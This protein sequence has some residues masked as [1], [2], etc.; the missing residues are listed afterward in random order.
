MRIAVIGAGAMGRWAVK[1]LALSAEVDEIVVGDYNDVQA[2]AVAEAFGGA[3]AQPVFVDARD[4]ESVKK[5]IAGCDSLV[6]ATQ[7]FW[8]I[9]VMHAA[10]AAKV[11]YTDMGGLFHVT[12]QQV[13]LAE[14]FRKAGVTAVIAMGGAPGVT[15]ILAK[16][17]AERLDTVE[18]AHALCGNVDDTDWSGYDGWVVPYSL[19]TLCD[20]FSVTAP[21]FVD[22]QWVMDIRG[23]EGAEAIDFGEPAGILEAHYT[24][25]SEPFTFWHTWKDQGL[26]SATFKLS[27]PA[28]FT[29]Q[30]R[31]LDAIGMTRTDEVE[32]RGARVRP[33][34]V[35]LKVV[36][37]IPRPVDVVLDDVDYLIGV[38][39][40]LEGGRRVEWRVR[41]V[42]PAHKEYGAGGGDV[43]TG[44]PPAIVA[45]MMARGD[46]AGPGVFVPEQIVPCE[47]F[48]EEFAR[49]GVTVDA[50]RRELLAAPPG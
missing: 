28:E 31:F 32:I 1:E 19:E 34:D 6:N 18:E 26:R 20:E 13:E 11:H 12:K 47:A 43:D 8:N 7:H 29:G 49:W 21:E 4:A 38:V 50:Q 45:R 33:R 35:L 41:A 3:K 2:R 22:G 48:F 24:I 14:E 37:D 10:A 42:V 25:H 17:G 39:R 40:G 44:I 30:M 9:S 46:I 27:L 36:S 15:N 5:A 16:Y 23:G